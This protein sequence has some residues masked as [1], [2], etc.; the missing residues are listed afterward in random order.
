MAVTTLVMVTTAGQ[1]SKSQANLSGLL[2]KKVSIY[3]DFSIVTYIY[4]CKSI[5]VMSL[6]KLRE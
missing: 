4:M 1:M 2:I 5:A 6:I 3:L